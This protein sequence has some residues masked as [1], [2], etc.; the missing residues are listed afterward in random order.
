MIEIGRCV[1]SVKFLFRALSYDIGCNVKKLILIILSDSSNDEGDNYC[2]HAFISSKCHL[3]VSTVKKHL[4]ELRD[5]G[6]IKW[7]QKTETNTNLYSLQLP[8]TDWEREQNMA[9]IEDEETGV[10][11]DLVER[12]F[13]RLWGVW[14]EC[15]KSVNV[16]NTS[17]KSAA[18]KKFKLLFNSRYFRKNTES[19]FRTEVNNMCDTAR[20]GHQ[21]EGFNPFTHMQ[22][23][24]FIAREDW[25]E[26]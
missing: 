24:R 26:C 15:K 23:N 2:S 6:I 5:M 3:S 11:G 22:L 8:M 20:R 18:S 9:V 25:R 4:A 19:D 21:I 16:K 10:D 13:A 1:M 17:S 7:G 12:G 14:R